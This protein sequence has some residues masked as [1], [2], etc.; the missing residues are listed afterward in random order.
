MIDRVDRSD[1]KQLVL[2]ARND[3]LKT[4]TESFYHS[5]TDF[6]FSTTMSEQVMSPTDASSNP[7]GCEK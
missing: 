2:V 1:G 4:M 6:L 3:T 5:A 7:A